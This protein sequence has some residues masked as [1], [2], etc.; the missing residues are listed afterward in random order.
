MLLRNV[1]AH[2]LANH[3]MEIKAVKVLAEECLI[4]LGDLLFAQTIELNIIAMHFNYVH[5]V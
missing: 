2:I 1:V 3:N 4:E 5:M